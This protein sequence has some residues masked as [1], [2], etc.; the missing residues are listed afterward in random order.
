M[1]L[2]MYLWVR[3]QM[4][5]KQTNKT[6]ITA[7]STKIQHISP[8]EAIVIIGESKPIRSWILAYAGSILLFDIALPGIHIGYT[9]TLWSPFL[10]PLT[11]TDEL[12]TVEEEKVRLEPLLSLCI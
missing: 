3:L 11:T 10:L 5:Q 4:Q 12:D 7:R 6:K 1:C 9:N 8:E 2:E